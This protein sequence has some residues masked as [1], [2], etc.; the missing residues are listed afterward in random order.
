[1]W[2]REQARMCV[3]ARAHACV[4]ECEHVHLKNNGVQPGFATSLSPR[5]CS[6]ADSVKF[7]HPSLPMR[8]P[9][10]QGLSDW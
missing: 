10:E 1:V 4:F 2:L 9:L 6:K 8:L 7:K 3:F 5:T